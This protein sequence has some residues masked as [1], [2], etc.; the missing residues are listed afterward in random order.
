MTVKELKDM[1][2][3]YNDDTNVIIQDVTTMGHDDCI[4]VDIN[5]SDY[6]TRTIA[7]Q[8]QSQDC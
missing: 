7:I 1:L 5:V 8:V 6:R 4:V 2:E 3:L